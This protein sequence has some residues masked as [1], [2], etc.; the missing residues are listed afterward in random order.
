MSEVRIDIYTNSSE[1]T[2]MEITHTNTGLSVQGEGVNRHKL[3][4]ALIE[5]LNKKVREN[6][7]TVFSNPYKV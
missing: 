4:N 5:E 3:K 7:K 2:V 1:K 6:S